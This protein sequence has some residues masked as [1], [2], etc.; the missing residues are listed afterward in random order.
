MIDN[1][2][3]TVLGTD[4]GHIRFNLVGMNHEFLLSALSKD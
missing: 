2:K 4:N 1:S 3:L